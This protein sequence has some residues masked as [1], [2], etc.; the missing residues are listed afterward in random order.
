M[1]KRP[2]LFS[3]AM[4]RAILQGRK[5]QT[6]RIV[7]LP[8][9]NSLGEWEPTTIGGENGGRTATGETVPLQGGIWH[10][11]TGDCLLSPHG[12]PGDR[13]WVRETH[14]N[15]WKLD[16]ANPEGPR[17]FSHVAAYAADGYE[18]QP[19]EKWIPSIHMLRAASRI[20]LEITS[21]RAE[22]LQSI[23]WDD[24]IAEGIPDPRRAA[25]RVD[26]VE[27]CVAQFRALWDGL[28]A[29][30]GHGWDANPW[31]WRIEFR[32]IKS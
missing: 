25:R 17:V 8:H 2:I 22:R 28:N 31:V 12:Q 16:E 32:R 18:L 9:M 20:T 11:R 15:W 26:P 4:V 24:A 1:T 6:R 19:G 27:G 23:S 5:T 10:T 21:V 14:L 7:K 13:L 29:A 30:R 3:A